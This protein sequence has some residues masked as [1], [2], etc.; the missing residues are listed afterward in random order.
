M[1]TQVAE[2][3]LNDIQYTTLLS[4]DEYEKWIINCSQK[5]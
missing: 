2:V 3:Y 1:I 4:V 5:P